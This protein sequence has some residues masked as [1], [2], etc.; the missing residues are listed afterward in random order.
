MAEAAQG[1]STPAGVSP[2]HLE[3]F[4]RALPDWFE[5]AQRPLPWRVAEAGARDPY[6]VW[7]SEVMLQQTRAEQARP[8]FDRFVERF[9]TL[10]DLADAPL[11]DVLKAWEGLGY[12]ARARNLHR[13]A[14]AVAERHGGRVPDDHAFRDLP[15]VGAYTAAAVLSLAHG[16][17][18]AALDGN[19]MRVLA[20]V[21]ATPGD[22]RAYSTRRELQR[23]A[24]AL[25]DRQNP[26]RH[27]EALMELGAIVC[28]PRAPSC[29]ACPLADVC[30][31]AES[32]RPEEWPEASPARAVPQVEVAVGIL[33]DDAGRV[34]V[35]RRPPEAMLGGL[36]EFPGGKV[37]PGETPADACRR[38][39]AEEVGV[40]VE[41]GAE[42]AR[43]RHA[44]S[45]L[46]VDIHAFHCTARAGAAARGP[47]PLRWVA[48]SEL[49]ALAM[50]RA[51][52]KVIEAAGMR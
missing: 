38:E 3:A 4:H 50:P 15:G 46:R 43:V 17:P 10:T 41:V 1:D 14:G 40:A 19:V 32:G 39:F 34:L 22:I 13:A 27:N 8:Y 45:H 2:R 6:R 7:V 44:Y 29:S 49:A 35:Q 47:L 31:A 18:L 52:R 5:H 26:G 21:F 24:D 25:L 28:T 16:R 9:P 11:D 33:P 42:A 51:T 12:Y 48:V 36:W 20:R 30:E 23:Q 37:E